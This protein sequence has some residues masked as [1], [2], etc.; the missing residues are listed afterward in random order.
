MYLSPSEQ[1][2]LKV[3]PQAKDEGPTHHRQPWQQPQALG[4]AHSPLLGEL[5]F[6]QHHGLSH[7]PAKPNSE[8]TKVESKQ[9]ERG[10]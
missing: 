8:E 9:E 6:Q 4:Q 7:A 1:L 5:H 10:Q 2:S 3:N